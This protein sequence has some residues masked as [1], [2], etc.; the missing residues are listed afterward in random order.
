MQRLLRFR[1]LQAAGIVNNWTSINYKVKHY[2][3]PLG[4]YLSPNTRVWTDEEISA[5]VDSRPSAVTPA[6]ARKGAA[7]RSVRTAKAA[8]AAAGEPSA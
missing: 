5:W 3:F 8:Q 7:A 2:G 1:D 4:K 6:N